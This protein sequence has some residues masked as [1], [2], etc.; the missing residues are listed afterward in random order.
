VDALVDVEI[1]RKQKQRECFMWHIRMN[2]DTALTCASVRIANL[3]MQDFDFMCK[4]VAR[5]SHQDAM[6]ELSMP[7]R[8]RFGAHSGSLLLAA[9][10]FR[11]TK[12]IA[13]DRAPAHS[14]HDLGFSHG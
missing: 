13:I 10:W 11:P 6:D 3:F 1:A 8:K 14:T 9:T 7:H 4:G 5:H 2:R 12:R